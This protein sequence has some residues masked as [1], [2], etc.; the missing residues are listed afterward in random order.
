MD[1]VSNIYIEDILKPLTKHFI[2]VFASNQIPPELHKK[3]RFSII[4]NLSKSHE[5]GS[6]WIAIHKDKHKLIYYD[7]VGFPLT[8][9]NIKSFLKKIKQDYQYNLFE[10]QCINS[11]LC[12]FFV[13]LFVLLL[14]QD[15]TFVQFKNLFSKK[16]CQNNK[17]VVDLLKYTIQNLYFY[18][19]LQFHFFSITTLVSGRVYVG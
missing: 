14:E 11:K 6:H 8:N 2:G 5:K 15:M 4:I 9:S 10:N 1:G 3:Q 13:I 19:F 12:G 18:A 7:S 17:I 16:C